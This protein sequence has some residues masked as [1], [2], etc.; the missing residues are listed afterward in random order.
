[1]EPVIEEESSRKTLPGALEA[2]NGGGRPFGG[3]ASTLTS[4]GG[5]LKTAPFAG[6][7]SKAVGKDHPSLKYKAIDEA[8]SRVV[9]AHAQAPP[10][11]T[12][13]RR[14]TIKSWN[15][16]AKERNPLAAS[17]TGTR[18]SRHACTAALRARGRST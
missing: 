1:M 13:P 16:T 5:A 8:V 9:M 3:T 17:L 15:S 12:L 18:T 7:R 14:S 6:T 10:K 11:P 4:T 2:S